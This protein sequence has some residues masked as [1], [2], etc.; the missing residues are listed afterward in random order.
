MCVCVIPWRVDRCGAVLRAHCWTPRTRTPYTARS[1]ECLCC[2]QPEHTHTDKKVRC[3]ICIYCTYT[4]K[5]N[6]NHSFISSITETDR[7]PHQQNR[8]VLQHAVHHVFLRQVFELVDEVDHVFAHRRAADS[9]DEAPVFKPRVLRLTEGQRDMGY[10]V[11]M[12]QKTFNEMELA[13]RL[14]WFRRWSTT[15]QTL[16]PVKRSCIRIRSHVSHSE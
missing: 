10:H 16:M 7:R 5:E 14:L 4:K 9:V 6:K 12:S 13:S 15:Q 11:S 3:Q 1:P 2:S 8:E